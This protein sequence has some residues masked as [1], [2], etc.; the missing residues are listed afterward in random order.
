M[1]KV[2]KQTD[3]KMGPLTVGPFKRVTYY[4]ADMTGPDI[5]LEMIA[6]VGKQVITQQEYVNIGINHILVNMIDNKFELTKKFKSKK[7]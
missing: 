7:K 1:K 3:I 5:Y 4:Q 6:T 2:K